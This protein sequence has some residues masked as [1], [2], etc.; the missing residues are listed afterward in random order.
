MNAM[1][2]AILTI[3]AGSSSIKFA[4]YAL[5]E[6]LARKPYLSGQIDG[7]GANAKLIA[8]DEGG[9]RIA[10]DALPVGVKH[11]EALD[12][13]LQWLVAHRAD[14]LRMLIEN[15][16][17]HVGVLK[18]AA[19]RL[20]NRARA[21]AYLGRIQM[22]VSAARFISTRISRCLRLSVCVMAKESGI[23]P[24]LWTPSK[25]RIRCRQWTRQRKRSGRADDSRTSLRQVL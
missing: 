20:A 9:T 19:Q 5:D 16:D 13:L 12:A 8:R 21:F 7:I 23:D 10:D 6:A 4:V 15:A 14:H 22:D 11:A 1:S 17:D 18:G 3:N 25:R 24:V 2:R